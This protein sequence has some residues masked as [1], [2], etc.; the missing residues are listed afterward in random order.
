MVETDC[1][2]AL[3]LLC[4]FD[5]HSQSHPSNDHAVVFKVP[6]CYR[7]VPPFK[8]SQQLIWKYLTGN[9]RAAYICLLHITPRV[10]RNSWTRWVLGCDVTTEGLFLQT[11]IKWDPS[12][13]SWR[14]CPAPN[15]QWAFVG[16]STTSWD[17]MGAG[18]SANPGWLYRIFYC[19]DRFSN[20][21]VG[22]SPTVCSFTSLLS[23]SLQAK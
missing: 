8:P 11:F 15:Q 22:V 19:E 13:T 14:T 5:F 1:G 17:P 16:V 9:H 18:I 4:R 6:C 7:D 12:C 20:T 2:V 10:S 3:D 23:Q 21:A